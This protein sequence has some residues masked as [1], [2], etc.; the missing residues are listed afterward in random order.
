M[1]TKR[2]VDHWS[3]LSAVCNTNE[4]ER[5]LNDL[6]SNNGASK[7]SEGSRRVL[8]R[9]LASMLTLCGTYK[10]NM[11]TVINICVETFVAI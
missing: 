5:A 10:E 8:Y 9:H 4:M 7:G 11:Q 3:V 6:I 2:T 1:K